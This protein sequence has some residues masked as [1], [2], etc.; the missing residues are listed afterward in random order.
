M[1]LIISASLVLPGCD[2][3]DDS[4]IPPVAA[5]FNS[6]V[7]IND[8]PEFTAGSQ[9]EISWVVDDGAAKGMD[10]L[11]YQVEVSTDA[12]FVDDV[13]ASTW[14]EATHHTFT[15]L[16]EG[17]T[18]YY[19]VMARNKDARTSPWSPAVS[20][21]QDSSAPTATVVAFD[22]D[23]TSLLFDVELTA[24]DAISGVD[25]INLW[26]R[27]NAGEWQLHG[28]V[29]AGITSFQTDEGGPH[30]FIAVA[31]DVVGNEQEMPSEAQAETLV[32]EQIILV[33]GLGF[34]WDVTNAVLKHHIHL[35]FWAHGIGRNTIRPVIDPIMAYEG[36]VG[37]PSPTSLESVIAVNYDGDKRAYSIGILSGREVADDVVNGVPIAVTY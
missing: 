36:D 18:L 8:E 3:V 19:R 24:E 37:F 16:L 31:T 13:T 28:P 33:D 2:S 25:G 26:F 1:L 34:E 23:E 32:P 15:D 21:T 7:T 9:N 30:E 12:T 22:E 20:S 17:Q 29:E 27:K 5:A 6:S 11:S 14:V 10:G 4:V 35:D